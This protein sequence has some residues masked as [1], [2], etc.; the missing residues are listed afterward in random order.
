MDF[1]I[2]DE[3][4][5]VK[6][7]VRQF[8]Q[9]EVI[10]LETE[11]RLA[12]GDEDLPSEVREKLQTKLRDLGLWALAVPKEYGGAGLGCLGMCL[13]TE[14]THRSTLSRTL[15]GGGAD[16]RLFAASD[17]LKEKYL[18]PT[19]RGEI[20]G[21][22]AFSEPGAGSDLAGI[23]TT[24]E[25]DGDEYIIN[26][27]KI[28]QSPKGNY[29]VVLAR[30][31]G[32]QRRDGMTRFIVDDETP[33]FQISRTVPLMGHKTTA[34]LVFDNC[35]VPA[36]HRLT[37]E[38]EAWAS[39]QLSLNMTRVYVAAR[40]LGMASRCIEM[41]VDYAKVRHTFG[42]PLSN[43]QGVQFMLADAAIGLHATRM[44]MYHTAWKAD[45]GEDI[46]HEASMLKVFSTEMGFNAVDSAMQIHGAAGYSKEMPI[47][48]FFRTIRAAR[49]YEGPN[50]VHR[51]V[52]AR[53]LFRGYA[54]LDTT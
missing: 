39:A 19:L 2:P 29:T 10:P 18:Y 34:E 50:E 11:Y 51:Y 43:R 31:K 24:A 38:G 25:R 14:E 23:Q 46:R 3:L 47:E 20:S 40:C 30:M 8:V 21:R 42:E 1:T 52:V 35:R 6:N 13:V 28:W 4:R 17:Y 15:I 33:G 45:N 32:T 9:E 7:L 54:G 12:D 5:M 44:M 41:A 48:S 53:N 37:P 27:T 36:S 22:G 26:G 16:P 49:I